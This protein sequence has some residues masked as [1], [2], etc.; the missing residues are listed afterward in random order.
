MKSQE[1]PYILYV[2]ERRRYKNFLNF[3]KAYSLSKNLKKDFCIVCCGGD[4]IT[5]NEKCTITLMTI[6]KIFGVAGVVV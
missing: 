3:L 2:G 4:K 1:K 5:P 6:P